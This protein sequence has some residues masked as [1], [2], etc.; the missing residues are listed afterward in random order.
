MDTF[1]SIYEYDINVLCGYISLQTDTPF[2]HVKQKRQISY[3]DKY[4]EFF[5]WEENTK[6]FFVLENKYIDRHFLEDYSEYYV[7]CFTNYKK[8]C[9]RI[10]FFQSEDSDFKSKF[11]EV[12]SQNRDIGEF[13]SYLGFIV[14]RPIPQTFLARICLK[15]YFENSDSKHIIRQMCNVSLF[16][17]KLEIETIACQEQDRILSACATS[18]LWSFFHAHPSTTNLQLPSS[19]FI[20]KT[21]YSE[22]NGFE[23]EFP[24]T[25]LS[26]E[27]ICRSLRVNGLVPTFF[28]F[29]NDKVSSNTVYSDKEFLLLKEYIYAYCSGDLPLILG[30]SV[31][32]EDN[33]EKK[34]LHAITIL[35]YSL[36]DDM[37]SSDEF[38]LISNRI[39]TFF[40]HD[41]R[42][43]PFVKI[44][45]DGML[46]KLDGNVTEIE[47]FDNEIYNPDTLIIGVYHKV[48]IPYMAIKETCRDFITLFGEY[49]L[50]NELSPYKAV[51]DSFIW[52][53]KLKKNS[54]LKKH[55]LE[56][57]IPNKEKY[58]IAS[59]PKYIWTAKAKC[60]GKEII[61]LLFDATDLSQGKVFLGILSLDITYAE[62]LIKLLK[63]Y[64]DKK[65]NSKARKGKLSGIPDSYLW[66]IIV[67]FR[68]RI[69]Y[70][71]NL[72]RLY[73]ITK[74]PEYIKTTEVHEDSLIDQCDV[75]IGCE[76]DVNGFRF[77]D[78][79]PNSMQY[80]WV[81][82]QDGFLCIGREDESIK[83][84]HPTL[85]DGMPARIGGEIHYNR[86]KKKWIVNPFSGRY[87]NDY[88]NEDK[89]QYLKNVVKY[90]FD[91][92]FPDQEFEIDPLLN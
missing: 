1:Y 6:I 63:S 87:S 31:E 29:S 52:E 10:H 91:L 24:N 11:D 26:T 50:E 43:G 56:S 82:D 68:K 20:T 7:R 60:D 2:H 88:K 8:Y 34:G 89:I 39:K 21:A 12:L 40:V 72:V 81:I 16:G 30:V 37:N 54:D 51:V 76:S 61:E 71:D 9:S 19:S 62:P 59:W 85:T 92:F 38:K 25:G 66:G 42:Y 22:E 83:R 86:E 73:G 80:I 23:G 65:Y 27:M 36:S 49:L 17:I 47:N 75:R 79:L 33:H 78:E 44:E 41:D 46:I 64:C 35:G 18:A 15:I 28:E 90:K 70:C 77:K 32:D 13:S 84:G 5:S 48:R 14:I 53:I 74:M 58:L 3:L 55:I 67:Y 4:L 57:K 45:S 69:T